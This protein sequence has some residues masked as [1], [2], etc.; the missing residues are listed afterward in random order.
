MNDER[1]ADW[2]ELHAAND[3]LGWFVGRPAF[4][5]HGGEWAMR[6]VDQPNNSH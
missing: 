5:R 6:A 3:R 1:H 4:E 2:A